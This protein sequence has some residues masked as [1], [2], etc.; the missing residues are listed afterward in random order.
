LTLSLGI[1][2]E[3]PRVEKYDRQSTVDLDVINPENGKPGALVFANRDGYGRGFQPVQ[4]TLEPRLGFSWSPTAKRNTVVRGAFYH[5]Y[6]GASLRTGPFGTQGFSAF[7]NFISPNQQLAAAVT[8]SDGVP[9]AEY[10]LPDLRPEAAN[11]TD[12]NL[13]T[14]SGRLPRYRYGYVS[15][16]RRLPHGMTVR[17]QARSYRGKNMFMDGDELPF[18]AIPLEALQYRDRLNDEAFRRTLRPYPQYQQFDLNH[19][20]PAGL[21]LYDSGDVSLE[22][23]TGQGLS[24]DM[25]YQLRRQYDDYTGPNVQNPFD[26]STAWA[27]TRGA[28]PHHFSLNYVY[29]LPLG[30]GKP[31][32]NQSGILAK[33]LGDWSLSGFTR[34]MSGTPLVLQPSFNNTG[35]VVSGL[36]VNAVDG[37]DPHLESPGPNLWFNPAAFSHPDDFTLGNVP[38]THPSLFG[39]SWQNHDLAISKRLPLTS[40]KSLELLLQSF[41]FLNTA[42][43]NSPDTEIGTA[44]APNANAG[45]IIGSYGGRVLQLGMR[46]NF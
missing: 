25:S 40:E 21:Y 8:L 15:L 26:R 34:W 45:K 16:E 9:A 22:K 4:T 28:R 44:A 20:Y 11:N 42:N 2:I 7:R 10:P 24:F 35:G 18:N 37:V 36:R 14:Q 23:R 17:A 13:M 32:L 39:P 12:A 43:W 6:S 46:Y 33:V 3:T 30:E 38:R 27:K 19:R 41:N 31:L 5:Y 1:D 29:E